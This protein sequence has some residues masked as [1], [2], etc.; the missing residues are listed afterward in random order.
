MRRKTATALATVGLGVLALTALPGTAQANPHWYASPS[1]RAAAAAD[2]KLHVWENQKKGGLHCAWSG[3]SSNWD[4]CGGMRN[5]A[6]SLHNNGRTHDVWLYYGPDQTGAHFCLNKGVY[7]ENIVH[8]YFP[9]NGAGGGQS[10][11][12]NIA[13]HKWVADC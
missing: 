9:H 11:N 1:T 3:N 10:L 7:L 6:S 2:G 4:S 8:H 12:D 13:S 5:E